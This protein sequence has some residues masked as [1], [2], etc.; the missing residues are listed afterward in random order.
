MTNSGAAAHIRSSIK[1]ISFGLF[2]VLVGVFS[3]AFPLIDEARTF[4]QDLRL[5]PIIDGIHVPLPTS[6]HPHFFHILSYFSAIWG[7]WLIIVCI[8]RIAMHDHWREVVHTLSDSIFWLGIAF[9]LSQ[10]EVG[11]LQFRHIFAGMVILVGI[12]IVIKALAR[13]LRKS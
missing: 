1:T 13:I 11:I 7:G 5:Q 3:I 4:F 9:L 2:L 8:L 6:H 10:I 12:G